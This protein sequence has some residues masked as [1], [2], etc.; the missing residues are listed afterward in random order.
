[1]MSSGKASC[2][3]INREQM[4]AGIDH[5]RQYIIRVASNACH[6]FLR[7]KYPARARLKDSLRDLL[8]RHPDFTIWKANDGEI[9][10]SFVDL[11]HIEPDRLSVDK[12]L[13][14]LSEPESL[15]DELGRLG[16]R[17]IRRTT[18]V[19]QILRHVGGSIEFDTLVTL[20]G[21][22]SGVRDQP[23]VALE[24]EEHRL[25]SAL[26]ES[27]VRCETRIEA[28]QTLEILWKVLSDFSYQQRAAYF[29]GFRDSQGEDPLNIIDGCERGPSLSHSLEVWMVARL[30]YDCMETNASRQC[31]HRRTS[32]YNPPERK[33]AQI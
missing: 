21:A 15:A 24:S 20:L 23:V 31:V 7:A 22:V 17:E 16:S 2:G 26:I 4:N 27:P 33:Q 9:Y 28:R 3:V 30:P 18:F 25:H 12:S 32:W 19:A 14:L 13:Q 8:E 10:A 5:F 29:L 1:M 6:D 11:Q